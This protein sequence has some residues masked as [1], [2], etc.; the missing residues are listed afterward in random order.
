MGSVCRF[1]RNGSRS[2]IFRYRMGPRR[3]YC[4]LG[5]VADVSLAQ[6]R[7]R[8][9]A[10]RLMLQNGQDPI[11]VKQGRR[12][13]ASLT[14]ARAMSF[15]KAAA[16]YI[17]LHK[18]GWSD[19]STLQW[20]TSIDTYAN[21][22]LGSLPI[23]EVDT[24]LV[25]KVLQPL[26]YSKAETASRAS[27]FRRCWTGPRCAA[28]AWARTRRLGVGT[29][30]CSYRLGPRSPRSCTTR[31]SPTPRSVPSWYSSGASHGRRASPGI[32]H[33]NR[34][35]LWARP[36]AR[37]GLDRPSGQGVDGAGGTYEGRRRAWV[38]LCRPS[39]GYCS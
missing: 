17:E 31:L 6:A 4:G 33:P 25:M 1:S 23:G 3:R 14:V 5:N 36:S 38:P 34:R 21:P 37:G 28:S 27:P 24:G 16:A 15:S 39:R 12:A 32:R 11:E 9:A 10:A 18:A 7:E 13:A 26:W 8:A 19:K 22:I 30:N 20:I 2:W 35:T 29:W